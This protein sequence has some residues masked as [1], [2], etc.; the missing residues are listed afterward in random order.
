M[1]IIEKP[2]EDKYMGMTG[3]NISVATSVKKLTM[4]STMTVLEMALMLLIL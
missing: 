3:Y 1:K 4:D 2:I